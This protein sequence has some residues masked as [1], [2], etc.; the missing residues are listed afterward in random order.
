MTLAPLREPWSCSSQPNLLAA[1]GQRRYAIKAAQAFAKRRPANEGS[2]HPSP[3]PAVRPNKESHPE[4][5]RTPRESKD[6]QSANTSNR[7]AGN[8]PNP[9]E[10]NGEKAWA[11]NIPP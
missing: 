8:S 5:A 10:G 1:T 2:L 6:P 11:E 9:P 7:A 3:D 4:R